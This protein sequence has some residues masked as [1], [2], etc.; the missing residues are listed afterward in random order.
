MEISVFFSV[1]SEHYWGVSS[2]VYLTLCCTYIPTS[3]DMVL[4]FEAVQARLLGIFRVDYQ[5]L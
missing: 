1:A 4:S 3:L 5:R 2:A